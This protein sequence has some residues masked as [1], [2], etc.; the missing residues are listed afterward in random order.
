MGSVEDDVDD[1]RPR[2]PTE[3]ATVRCEPAQDAATIEAP[4]LDADD[5]SVE[6]AGYG[7]GV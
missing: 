4:T 1:Q 5:R 7:Y 6:E 2:T 3:P